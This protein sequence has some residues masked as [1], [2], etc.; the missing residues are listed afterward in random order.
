M[1]ARYANASFFVL[2][3]PDNPAD[4][5]RLPQ[6]ILNRIR[7]VLSG[8]DLKF[9]IEAPSKVSLFVY[10]NDSFIVESFLPEET[11]VRVVA[12]PGVTHITDLQTK[13]IIN[14][15]DRVTSRIWGRKT[16]EKYG[17]DIIVKPHS[18]RVFQAD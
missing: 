13:E 2:T 1:Q 17:F 16:E 11:I 5:Y 6:G 8:E 10:D 14:S 12:G 3:I 9:R 18:Y 4:L 7:D 15:S